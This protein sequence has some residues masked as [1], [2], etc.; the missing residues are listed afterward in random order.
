M[1]ESTRVPFL[2]RDIGFLSWRPGFKA[3]APFEIGAFLR[4]QE[5]GPSMQLTRNALH[6]GRLLDEALRG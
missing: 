5:P 2:R 4:R 6:E 1:R 3:L